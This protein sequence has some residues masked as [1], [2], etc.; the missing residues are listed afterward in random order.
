MN[1]QVTEDKLDKIAKLLKLNL[2]AMV[3]GALALGVGLLPQIIK[4]RKTVDRV[5]QRFQDFADEVQPVVASG[6]GKAIETIKKMDASRLSETATD[7]SDEL[8]KA[9]GERAKK[10]LERK[11]SK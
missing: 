2:I 1:D 6:A 5:E 7:S 9:A 11:N 8:I 3:V 10:L 4:A